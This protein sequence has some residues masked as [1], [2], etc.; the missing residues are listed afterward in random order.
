[1]NKWHQCL[2]RSERRDQSGA[3]L[4]DIQRQ[5][6]SFYRD[7]S[8]GQPFKFGNCYNLCKDWVTFQDL[9]QEQFGPTSVQRNTSISLEEDEDSPTSSQ[10]RIP[11]PM[12]RNAARKMRQK[13]K[14]AEVK[15]IGEEMVAG[16]R[17]MAAQMKEAE[18]ERKRR[19]KK[20]RI[21][22]RLLG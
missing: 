21:K 19:E 1:M 6:K 2:E 17:E 13:G 4:Q 15:A 5:A 22:E 9:P 14:E 8:G 3:N 7:D 20:G 11:R 12:G 10:T 18:E 16:M